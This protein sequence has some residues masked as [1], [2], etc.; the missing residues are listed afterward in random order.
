MFHILAFRFLSFSGRIN[1]FLSVLPSL[2][3]YRKHNKRD[4]K[5]SGENLPTSVGHLRDSNNLERMDLQTC[6]YHFGVETNKVC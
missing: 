6:E 5:L 4:H 1:W 3:I 2:I